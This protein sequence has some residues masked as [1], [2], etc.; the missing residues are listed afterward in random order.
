[1][2]ESAR[3]GKLKQAPPSSAACH[4]R[5]QDELEHKKW[6][7]L[8]QIGAV[9]FLW[10]R[11]SDALWRCK[12]E[13]RNNLFGELENERKVIAA[14]VDGIKYPLYF[15]SEDMS[16]IESIFSNHESKPRCEFIAPLDPFMW[17]RKLIITMFEFD[18]TWEIYTPVVKRK[19]GHY[20][21]PLLYGER[22]IGRIEAVADRK[23]GEL[24]VKNIWYENDVRVNKNIQSAVDKCFQR[25]ALFNGC[26]T[27]VARV[28]KT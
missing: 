23:A 22:F 28:E 13:E 12:T 27:V 8:R 1:M 2:T 24:V 19:Y 10:N 5:K 4:S 17:D 3:H 14:M 15:R 21:L 20:V 16:L 7:L 25:F 9:G 6:R 18:Y 26:A 11:P